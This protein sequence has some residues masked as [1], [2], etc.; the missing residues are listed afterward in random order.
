MLRFRK[1]GLLQQLP[2]WEQGAW[3]TYSMYTHQL[4]YCSVRLLLAF[5]L[6]CVH[7]REV[8]ANNKDKMTWYT[9]AVFFT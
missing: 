7:S 9:S 2:Q 6:A 3:V 4:F 5:N 8:V 1:Q